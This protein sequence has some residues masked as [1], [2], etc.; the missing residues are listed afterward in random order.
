MQVISSPFSHSLL[1]GVSCTA[2]LRATCFSSLYGDVI[3]LPFTAVASVSN[4]GKAPPH[5]FSCWEHLP[6]RSFPSS[7][8]YIFITSLKVDAFIVAC[9]ERLLFKFIHFLS[10][11]NLI[12]FIK[13]NKTHSPETSS[14]NWGGSAELQLCADGGRAPGPPLASWPPSPGDLREAWGQFGRNM[15]KPRQHVQ[16]W[17][18]LNNPL[19]P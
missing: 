2:L 16:G 4:L 9:W 3:K 19:S 14:P 5:R 11:L 8:G 7:W 17:L 12:R 6:L 18:F 13:N 1:C 15:R 10:N